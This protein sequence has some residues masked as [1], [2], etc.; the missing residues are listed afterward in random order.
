MATWP[1]IPPTPCERRRRA[2][3]AEAAPDPGRTLHAHPSAPVHRLIAAIAACLVLGVAAAQTTVTIATVNNPDM[4]VMQQ[5]SPRFTAE[6]PDIV[7]HW[8]ILDEATLRSRV[9]TDAATGAASFD[10]VT[11]GAYETPLWGVISWLQSVDELA[12]QYPDVAAGYDFDDL[13]PAIATA[14]RTTASSSPCRSTAS[15]PSRCTTSASSTRPG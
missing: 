14:S 11:I 1:S 9:T 2:A 10:I 8:L 15:P 12:E 13:L 7:L 5:L 3:A 6:N 4:Q